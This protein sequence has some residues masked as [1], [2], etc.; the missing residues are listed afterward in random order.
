LKVCT[1]AE[2]KNKPVALFEDWPADGVYVRLCDESDGTGARGHRWTNRQHDLPG[3]FDEKGVLYCVL[4]TCGKET[5][6]TNPIS[7]SRWWRQCRALAVEPLTRN[8]KSS[9][10]AKTKTATTQPTVPARGCGWPWARGA[11]ALGS[12]RSGGGRGGQDQNP[13]RDSKTPT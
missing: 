8:F 7:Q 9:G 5:A 13:A 10:G 6:F 12:V 1:G 3:R 11:W 4:A 2:A